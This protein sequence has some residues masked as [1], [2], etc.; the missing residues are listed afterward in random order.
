MTM[1]VPEGMHNPNVPF[2]PV[3]SVFIDYNYFFIE[4]LFLAIWPTYDESGRIDN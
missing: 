3:R 4:C 1:N 2:F